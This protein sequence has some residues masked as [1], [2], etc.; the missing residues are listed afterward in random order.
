MMQSTQLGLYIRRELARY[1]Y[2]YIGRG[3]GTTYKCTCTLYIGCVVICVVCMALLGS[4][5]LPSASL[6][7]MYTYGLLL[8]VYVEY[9]LKC[10]LSLLSSSG[11]W[12]FQCSEEKESAVDLQ[13]SQH[14]YTCNDIH[15]MQPITRATIILAQSHYN[16][17]HVRTEYYYIHT[18]IT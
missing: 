6:T 15:I 14:T 18:T 16:Y 8:V 17:V 3:L 1:M 12:E 9:I 4:F 13:W 11:L 7:N 5:F 10:S 2:M